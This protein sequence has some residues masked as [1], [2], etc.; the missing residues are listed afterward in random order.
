MPTEPGVYEM[1]ALNP[2]EN[3]PFHGALLTVLN[4]QPNH[5]PLENWT[6]YEGEIVG[7]TLS[8]VVVPEPATMLLAAFAGC[9]LVATRN[10][11][12]VTHVLWTWGRR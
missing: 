5:Y 6:A 1:D 12:R 4:F 10:L 11:S 7:E 8:F 3:K 9:I 2:P